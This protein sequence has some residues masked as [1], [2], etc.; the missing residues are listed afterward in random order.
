MTPQKS[1]SNTR[2]GVALVIVL[3]MLVLL[4]GLIVAF[5]NSV[6]TERNA[7]KADSNVASARAIADSTVN[8]VVAQIREAT[9]RYT[10]TSAWASQPGAIRTFS[11][12]SSGRIPMDKGAY[13]YGYSRG[14][15]DYVYKLYSAE[16][17]R[18]SAAD[19]AVDGNDLLSEI[20][21]IDQWLQDPLKPVEGYVDM[22][23][24]FV[25]RF[26]DASGNS[27][28]DYIYEPRYP[29]LDPR[30]RADANEKE[31][32]TTFGIV[33][34]FD[35]SSVFNPKDERRTKSNQPI[36]MLPMP[37]KW[38]YVLKDGTIGPITLG[39]DDN[40]VVGRTAF[41]TDDESTKLN[42]N[43]ASEGTFWDTPSVSSA[44]EAGEVTGGKTLAGD[45]TSLAFAASQPIRNEFQRY[46]GHPAT[47][48]LSPVFGWLWNLPRTAPM[49]YRNATYNT[50]KEAIYQMAPF[51]LNGRGTS[52]GGSDNPDI[53][54]TQVMDPGPLKL[55]KIPTAV[56]HLYNNIDEYAFD[57][58]RFDTSG[59]LL[60]DP[61][62]TPDKLEKLRGFITANSKASEL[63]LFN[64]PRVTIWP[65]N[66]DTRKRTNF[67]NLFAFTSTLGG[68]PFHFVRQEAKDPFIDVKLDINKYLLGYLKWVTGDGADAN[69][70]P[71]F[72]GSFAAKYAANNERDQIL[73]LI[74]DYVRCVNLV[75]T[76]TSR[77][78][79]LKFIPYTPFFG[80][81][82]QGYGL[83]NR[84]F[85]YSGQVTPT[86]VPASHPLTEGKMGMGRFLTMSEA[87]LV[88]YRSGPYATAVPADQVPAHQ[89]N[90]KG[91]LMFEMATTMPGFPALRDTYYTRIKIIRDFKIKP[92]LVRSGLPTLYAPEFNLFTAGINGQASVDDGLMNVVNVS[93]HELFQ[94]RGFMPFMGYVNQFAY[95]PEHKAHTNPDLYPSDPNFSTGYNMSWK[96]M[97][98]DPNPNPLT[99]VSRNYSRGKTLVYYPYVGPEP[100]AFPRGASIMV[101]D[102]T[103]E[104][105]ANEFEFYPGALEVEIWSG[106]CP[107]EPNAPLNWAR[108][109]QTVELDFSSNLTPTDPNPLVFPIPEG[110]NS[111]TDCDFGARLTAAGAPSQDGKFNL[112][113]AGGNA[114]ASTIR[115]LEFTGPFNNVP[116]GVQQDRELRK[117]GDIRL[118]ASLHRVPAS[119]FKPRNKAE[120]VKSTVRTV[121]G[122][123]SG[124]G[125]Y[126]DV[127]GS[128]PAVDSPQLGR[129]AAGSMNITHDNDKYHMLPA[130]INGVVNS[131]GV[132]GDFDRGISKHVD[133]PFGGKVDEGNVYFEYTQGTVDY[134]VPYFRGRGIEETGQSFFSPNR[135]VSSAVMFGSL[136]TGV[137]RGKP[138]QTLL[139]RPDRS[140]PPHPGAALPEDHLLLDLF[141]LPI[142][143]PYAISEPFAT[144]GKVNLNYIMA[145]FGYANP[146]KKNLPRSRSGATTAAPSS[147]IH[148]DTALRGV[149]RSTK[150]MAVGPTAPNFGH[151]EHYL[152]DNTKY[153]FDI[154]ID[155]TIAHIQKRFLDPQRGLFRS[156]SEICTVDLYPWGGP[157]VTNWGT[158]W[159]TTYT[160]T[161]D[162]MRE[163][164]YSHIYPRVTTKSNVYNVHM[165]CQ[166]IT[167]LPTAKVDGKFDYTNVKEEDIQVQSEYR[168]SALIER[169]VD[170]NDL[171]LKNYN[172]QMSSV[173][174]YYRFRVIGTK[175]FNPR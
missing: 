5:F 16:N 29:I 78:G 21:I 66:A 113:A 107:P 39:T 3:A 6:R 110:T 49:T 144:S 87:L 54:E 174:P 115:S 123:N 165:R 168:G 103:K 156:A 169:F 135:Q 59:A 45:S 100:V 15:S 32:E 58:D 162:N 34:G 18:V 19:Y 33:E 98:R 82:Q 138:W 83:R 159:D 151:G 153:R 55:I 129:L 23:E 40:P 130:F 116:T 108:H 145:P 152:N 12:S 13:Q 141:H 80:Q 69:K 150:V 171:D 142:V 7:T 109:V 88:F 1:P 93:N 140:S 42:I 146:N 122:L 24:P 126:D 112:F 158:F 111:P 157:T 37:V 96:T 79:S 161:G 86:Q 77:I 89:K 119:Y 97:G 155:E 101:M 36:P 118:G 163:R 127:S 104:R 31:S 84:S 73:T 57:P 120:W 17:M 60:N 64:R 52:K 147:Y 131:D 9:T 149:L 99:N 148:R 132:Q 81:G 35:A 75:D 30:A 124:H 91:M 137:A 92:R 11:G 117:T 128:S 63:N 136:P 173:D 160:N 90:M 65:L 48:C 25:S 47:T 56:K 61:K 71:G 121:H 53:W 8:M 68:R 38:L 2:Q 44:Q 22:N 70:I 94:G 41:W 46:P 43:T 143:E 164:P 50:F 95:F 10:K 167:I 170:P 4:S 62:V 27:G 105:F 67:D 114:N 85:D 154:D 20:R 166:A 102:G 76:G 125:E 106:E 133:G 74:F 72:G 172:Y 134:R 26:P 51:T 139:F 14:G 175:Q 28:Q